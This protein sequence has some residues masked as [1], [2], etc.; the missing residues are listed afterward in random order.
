MSPEADR[1]VDRLAKAVMEGVVRT[2]AVRDDNIDRAVEVIRDELK[3]LL[4]GDDYAVIRYEVVARSIPEHQAIR[5]VV[6]SCAAKLLAEP[7]T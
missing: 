5:T 7:T 4:L 6:L 3:A 2:G 1:R